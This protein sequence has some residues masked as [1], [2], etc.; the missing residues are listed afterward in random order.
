MFSSKRATKEE[1]LKKI[2][3]YCAYQERSHNEVKEK[4][5]SFGLYKVQTEEILS[6]LIEENYLNEERFAKQFAGGKFR[7]KQWGRRKIQY[8]LQQKGVNKVNIKLGL[9]EIEEEQYLSVLQKLASKKWKELSGQQYLVRQARTTGYLLQKG[10]EPSLISNV[11]S[12]I[13]KG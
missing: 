3:N 7:M 6:I 2:K 9:K 1:A 10:Y 13:S 11:I 5:Y 12:S 4:L 8:E